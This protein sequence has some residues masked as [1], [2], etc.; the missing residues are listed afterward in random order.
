M[1]EDTRRAAERF[2]HREAKLLDD[3]DFAGWLAL[4]AEDGVY[5]VPGRPGQS[6]P[7]GE[8]SIV[9]ED[10]AILEMRLRRLLHPHA[11][12][13]SPRPRTTHL[14]GNVEIA[15]EGGGTLEV[16]SAFVMTEYRA[17]ARRWFS[18]RVKHV[19][20]PHQDG[21]R[22]VLKR[23]DLIDCDGVHG[24]MSVPF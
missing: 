22:I 4:F 10:R 20:R 14:V 15:A 9:Y 3:G 7:K 5:W 12:A 8:A 6:D 16:E 23:V 13:A 17:E 19:L 2:L 24:V 11:Y 18:G 1:S 21:F